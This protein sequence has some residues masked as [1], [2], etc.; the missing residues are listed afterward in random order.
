[1]PAMIRNFESRVTILDLAE[2]EICKGV[3]RVTSE[4]GGPRAQRTAAGTVFSTRRA[5]PQCGRSFEELDPRLFS[6]NS[7]HGWCPECYGTGLLLSGFDA[8][9]TGEEIWWNDWWEG[10]EKPCPACSGQRC[11]GA[12]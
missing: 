1:M 7:K 2:H 5:C 11:G 8:E 4:A 10:A 3:I 6:Y 12:G 9:Q